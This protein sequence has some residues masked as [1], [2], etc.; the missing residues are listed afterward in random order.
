M[1]GAQQNENLVKTERREQLTEVEDSFDTPDM[2]DSDQSQYA[3]YKKKRA[4]GSKDSQ[5]DQ[6]QIVEKVQRMLNEILEIPISEIQPDSALGDLGVDS[7]M[8]TEVLTEIKQ[9]FNVSISAAKFQDFST[10]QCLCDYLQP[11][12]SSSTPLSVH[13]PPS[14]STSSSEL[15]DLALSLTPASSTPGSL[16]NGT[17]TIISFLIGKQKIILHHWLTNLSQA[18]GAIM[19]QLRMKQILSASATRYIPVKLNW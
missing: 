10:V 19:I 4:F 2:I 1:D 5:P 14:A 6:A 9:G 17:I 3:S 8:I 15:S 12:S 18:K 7:L 16:E 11:P 13:T